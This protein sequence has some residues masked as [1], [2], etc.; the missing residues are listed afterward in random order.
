MNYGLFF[1]SC[2]PNELFRLVCIQISSIQFFFPSAMIH[3]Q[4]KCLISGMKTFLDFHIFIPYF[5]ID[6][7]TVSFAA[8]KKGKVKDFMLA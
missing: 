8:V 4:I 7:T 1:V 5:H 2:A 3:V 6:F